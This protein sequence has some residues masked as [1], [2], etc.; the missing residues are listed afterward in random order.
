M[1]DVWWEVD[2][3]KDDTAP[4]VNVW[5]EAFG[6][7]GFDMEHP[8]I[9]EW[10]ML[11]VG[12][13]ELDRDSQIAAQRLFGNLKLSSIE[14]GDARFDF[15]PGQSWRFDARLLKDLKWDFLCDWGPLTTDGRPFAL[16]LFDDIL[17]DSACACTW[18]AEMIESLP[19]VAPGAPNRRPER[20]HTATEDDL[21]QAMKLCGQRKLDPYSKKY[22]GDILRKDLNASMASDALHLYLVKRRRQAAVKAD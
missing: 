6:S 18:I 19:V 13:G 4:K 1:K 8:L 7:M 17:Q 10:F 3:R 16:A 15:V 2:R 9:A 20:R 21:T 11:M 5:A 12:L 14:K 22:V